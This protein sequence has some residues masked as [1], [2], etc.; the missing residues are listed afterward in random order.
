MR[1]ALTNIALPVNNLC[2]AEKIVRGQITDL[3]NKHFSNI[4]VQLS[5]PKRLN[6]CSNHELS[7]E[8]LA[9]ITLTIQITFYVLRIGPLKNYLNIYINSFI[10]NLCI[11]LNFLKGMLIPKLRYKKQQIIFHL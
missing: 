11:L 1:V 5:L 9:L 2:S 7:L 4:L 8:I 3:R 6:N 10:S